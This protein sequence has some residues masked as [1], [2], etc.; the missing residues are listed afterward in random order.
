MTTPSVGSVADVTSWPTNTDPVF[1]SSRRRTKPG[2]EITA[3]MAAL[4][5]KGMFSAGAFQTADCRKTCEELKAKGVEFV[6]E[7][8]DQFYGGGV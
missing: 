1:Y 4:L 3:A 8:K 7:P 6:S 5:K 2:M